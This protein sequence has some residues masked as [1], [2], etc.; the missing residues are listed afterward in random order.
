MMADVSTDVVVVG[1]G[2]A[3]A[4]VA[5]RLAAAGAKVALLDAGPRVDRAQAVARFVNAPVKTPECPY[6]PSAEADHPLSINVHH[7]YRQAGPDAFKSTYLKVVGGTTWHW[8]GTCLRFLPSDFR[9][10][11][12]YGKG[13]D[14]PIDYQALEPYYLQAE[15]ELGVAGTLATPWAPRVPEE[16]ASRRLAYA[17]DARSGMVCDFK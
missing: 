15:R 4:L 7:Y 9:L 12:L 16:L 3:G 5:A 14:W 6:P 11:S 17:G 8:L 13:V 2:V 1:A 10:R